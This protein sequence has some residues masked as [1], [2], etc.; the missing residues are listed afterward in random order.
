LRRYEEK[1]GGGR[2]IVLPASFYE[3]LPTLSEVLSCLLFPGT[4][5]L[6]D[7][8]KPEALILKT[9]TKQVSISNAMTITS[10]KYGSILEP[11]SF[12]GGS[13]RLL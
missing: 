2:V 5:I 13:E 9:A 7:T 4:I 8:K 1:G 6:H 12:F 3:F 11:I 10:Q